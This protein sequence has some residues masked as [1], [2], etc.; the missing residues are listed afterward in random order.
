M[1]LAR[2]GSRLLTLDSVT[3]RWKVRRKPSH[4]QGIAQSPLSFA[5]ELADQPAGRLVVL[6]PIARPDNWLNAPSG[7][8]TP[9]VVARYVAAAVEAGWVPARRGPVFKVDARTPSFRVASS[10]GN[11]LLVDC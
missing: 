11:W 10:S 1:A 5:V 6:L 3:Y 8:A 4:S 7:V 2:K 9:G